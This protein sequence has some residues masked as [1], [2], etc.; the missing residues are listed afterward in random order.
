MI[1]FLYNTA[2]TLAAPAGAA[3]LAVHPRH[4][5][6]LARWERLQEIRRGVNKSLEKARKERGMGQSL[7][8]RVTV[9]AAAETVRFLESFGDDLRDIFLVSATELREGAVPE[10]EEGAVSVEVSAAGGEKCERCWGYTGDVGESGR[11]PGTCRRCAGILE[12]MEL[13]GEA[14]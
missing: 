10:G 14:G 4:R 8:A 1:R 11:F 13:D 9:T 6:L 3:Y 5:S 2:L 12:G 7:A